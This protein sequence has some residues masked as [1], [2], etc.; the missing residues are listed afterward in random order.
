MRLLLAILLTGLPPSRAADGNDSTIGWAPNPDGRGTSSLIISCVVTLTLCV[1]S[2][3]H[4]NVPTRPTT[5]SRLAL[6][7]TKWVL[8]GIFAPELVVATAASQYITVR[9]L[10]RE[11]ERDAAFRRSKDPSNP[12]EAWSTA[13][14][15]YAVMGGFVTHVPWIG[16]ETAGGGEDGHRAALT[17]SALRLLSFVGRLP[18][19]PESQIQDKSKADWMAKSIVCVQAAWM[20]AQVIGRLLERLPVSLLEINTCGHV[21]CAMAL[22]LLWWSKPLDVQD[23]TVLARDDA[24]TFMFL[25]SQIG[26]R[27]DGIPDIRCFC[28]NY[29]KKSV[30]PAGKAGD[31]PTELVVHRN[32]LPDTQVHMEDGRFKC[33]TEL[34]LGSV[35][36]RNLPNFHG[37]DGVATK[38]RSENGGFAF[39]YAL[40]PKVAKE[41][42][43]YCEEPYKSLPIRH[44]KVYCRR[45]RLKG[46]SAEHTPLPAS[47]LELV[48][49]VVDTIWKNHFER[50]LDGG[51]RRY[52]RLYFTVVDGLGN[53]GIYLAETDYLLRHMPNF[54]SLWNLGLGQVDVHKN[55]LPAIFA[56]T[57]LAY[58]GLHLAAWRD[59]FPSSAERVL[60]IAAALWIA[61]SGGLAWAMVSM[62]FLVERFVN[63]PGR[64]V[65]YRN[66]KKAKRRDRWSSRLL[67][68]LVY[69]VGL[70][71]AV[72]RI[73]IVVEAFVSL[74][75]VPVDMYKTADWSVFIPH[76]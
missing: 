32:L 28:Y 8:Y 23:P 11:I 38:I 70:V 43:P 34:S 31:A 16:A 36:T 62:S 18:R 35:G 22:Y 21:V 66:N 6:E 76:L 41:C 33:T 54:P 17:A 69:V 67:K 42:R 53:S 55:L 10:K 50:G 20:V 44:N 5:K 15:F 24:V 61:V 75:Q 49:P 63:S 64:K 52:R 56:F 57:A 72:A 1:W 48:T 30:A 58:G 26:A 12:P 39:E 74:R 7:K 14:C 68:W 65:E 46:K 13:Q 40:K 59:Y 9:W 45:V 25:C 3:L 27:N 2:A 71:F 73:F 29:A 19:I 4:L 60:W 37:F 47:Y 51:M